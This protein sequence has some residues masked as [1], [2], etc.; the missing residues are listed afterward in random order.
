MAVALVVGVRQQNVGES[1]CDHGPDGGD[2]QR[3]RL[4][5]TIRKPSRRPCESVL[6]PR[7]TGARVSATR[8]ATCVRNPTLRGR[9]CP[10]PHTCVR[11]PTR[12]VPPRCRL[13]YERV[14]SASNRVPDVIATPDPGRTTVAIRLSGTRNRISY[15]R[16]VSETRVLDDNV[17]P[18]PD[19]GGV[20]VR[21]PTRKATCVR[22]PTLRGRVCPEPHTCVRN[23]TRGVPPRCRLSYE[24]V[25]SASNRVPDVI[26]TPDP[27]RT[28]VAIRLS[29]TRNRISY[30]RCVSETRQSP[31]TAAARAA[32]AG[33]GNP[34]PYG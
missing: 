2:R 24:R 30:A 11:N 29:G 5:A 21:N 8:K 23:P 17:C 32:V 3:Y 4:T 34:R 19:D 10:E 12:G 13:S 1:P 6:P 7:A 16:C 15:A 31:D 22:N 33:R 18:E 9:V 14:L 20:C 27:G 26:A 28:T 25:L